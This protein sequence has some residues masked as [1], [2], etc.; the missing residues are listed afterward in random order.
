MIDTAQALQMRE[1]C[2]VVLGDVARLATAIHERALQ[3]RRTPMIGRTHGVHAEP[4]TL[5]VK[6]AL[7]YDELRR[8]A[9]RIRRARDTVSVGKLSGAVG[10]FAHLPPAVEAVLL[11]DL[12]A[13][14]PDLVVVSG[15]LTQR[16]R[17]AQFAAARRFPFQRI[18]QA[19]GRDG[20][21]QQIG[22]VALALNSTST[23]PVSLRRITC[24]KYSVL[25]AFVLASSPPAFVPTAHAAS[26]C[27]VIPVARWMIRHGAAALP[28]TPAAMSTSLFESVA[29]STQT[30]P[31]RRLR[32][33]CHSDATEGATT[34]FVT[35]PASTAA[36]MAAGA[37][38]GVTAA[39]AALARRAR[40]G[41]TAN[42][43]GR[44][45]T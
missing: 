35:V 30:S 32:C 26:S 29:F 28:V 21:Q 13:L 38:R 43:A 33:A 44:S 2:D 27:F 10:M 4:M 45:R 37:A 16:A 40:A 1:A 12:G 5:G 7:W 6:L 22:A 17:R 9:A 31:A 39:A 20:E 8:D 18:A 19:F 42:P 24:R 15:D 25:F 14:A 36:S 3:H 23:T 41:R 34:L 11:D